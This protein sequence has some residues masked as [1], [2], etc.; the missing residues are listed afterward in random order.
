M[1]GQM[2][3]YTDQTGTIEEILNNAEKIAVVGYSNKTYRAGHYVPAYLQEQGYQIIPVNPFEKE[4]L[5]EEAYTSLE[6]V[7]QPVDL[8]LIFRRSEEV[9]EVVEQAV[10][11]NAKWVWMQLGIVHEQAAKTAEE[12]GLGVVMD[13]CMLVEHKNRV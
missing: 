9:E 10:E 1:N 2:M 6:E 13:K 3:I 8:V 4:G 11:V 5:G 12:A 7:P